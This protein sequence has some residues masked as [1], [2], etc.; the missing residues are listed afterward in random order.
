MSRDLLDYFFNDLGVTVFQSRSPYNGNIFRRKLLPEVNRRAGLTSPALLAAI[1][2]V[3]AQTCDQKIFLAT[4]AYLEQRYVMT[5]SQS[6][7]RL[8]GVLLKSFKT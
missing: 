3:A 8:L 7:I 4:H 5:Y 2:F 6:L 1:L